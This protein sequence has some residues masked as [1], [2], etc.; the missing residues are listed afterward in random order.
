MV[1]EGGALAE[2]GLDTEGRMVLYFP[3][4]SD[5]TTIGLTV[6]Y[7]DGTRAQATRRADCPGRRASAVHKRN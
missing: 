6:T 7:P 4:A 2:H 1:L 3:C 5:V